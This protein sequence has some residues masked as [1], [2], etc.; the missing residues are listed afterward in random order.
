MSFT[1]V[2]LDYA[3]QYQRALDQ[4][5]PHVL[6]FHS[7]RNAPANTTYRWANGNA[8]RIPTITTSGRVDSD[9]D[10]ITGTHRNH[11]IA[12]KTYELEFERKWK[13]MVDPIDIDETNIVTTIA[14]ITQVFNEEQKFP[15]MDSYFISKLYSDWQGAGGTAS[16]EVVT[17]ANVLHLF[18]T[19]MEKMDED[20]VPVIG[21]ILYVT[22]NVMRLLREAEAI[23]RAIELRNRSTSITTLI[24][25]IDNVRIEV[26]PSSLMRT[27]YD[28]TEGAVPAAGAEQ[29][30]M[31]LGHNSCVAAPVKYT[32][33]RLDPPAAISDDKWVYYERAYEDV[34]V[35]QHKYQGLYF[36]VTPIV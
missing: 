25:D 26:V 17:E 36:N 18:Q 22:P 32:S 8:I 14:N 16:T 3:Q 27:L 35:L 23:G 28:F 20:R 9:R 1:Q 11:N 12:W 5:Y 4:A 7:L 30:N 24:S 33:V 31:V 13:T 19:M 29:I 34:F 2:P 21:R 15:E 10:V 6:H